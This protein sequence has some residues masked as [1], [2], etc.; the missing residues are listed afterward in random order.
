ME[1]PTTSVLTEFGARAIAVATARGFPAVGIVDLDPVLAHPV[2]REHLEHYEKWI[3]AGRHGEMGYLERGAERRRDPR[4]LMPSAQSL[5]AVAIPYP[6]RIE[7]D[8]HSP[9]YARYLYG[10]DYHD[11]M[12]GRLDDVVSD[13]RA[14]HPALSAK[15]CV[16]TSALL[17]RTWAQFAGLGWIGKNTLLIHP[18]LGS[19]L[20]LGFVLFSETA[21]GEPALLPNY[22]GN[23]TRCLEQCPTGALVSPGTLDSNRCIAYLTLEKRGP[24]PATTD[25]LPFRRF[26]AGCD[27]C[28][29]ACPY[30]L[31]P[32]KREND[33]EGLLAQTAHIETDLE[34]L[35]HETEEAY[36]ARVKGTALSRVKYPDSRRNLERYLRELGRNDG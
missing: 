1:S 6:R 33:D 8:G 30:N 3:R 13:L 24:L 16:D 14:A 25:T 26:I 20:F 2:Y 28:Q 22:C 5:L 11:W 35:R 4:N 21:G 19:Y 9:R 29:E 15:I 23:C 27:I 10:P 12:K 32:V 7:D 18:K 36:R 17:E 31:K 34:I